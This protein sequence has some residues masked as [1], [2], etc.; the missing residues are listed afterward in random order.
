MSR[1]VEV[2]RVHPSNPSI[3][4]KR[5][6]IRVDTGD[7]IKQIKEKY[8]ANSP[9]RDWI[10]IDLKY[11]DKVLNDNDDVPSNGATLTFESVIM[12]PEAKRHVIPGLPPHLNLS[13]AKEAPATFI[14]DSERVFKRETARALVVKNGEPSS[15]LPTNTNTTTRLPGRDVLCSYSI[16]TNGCVFRILHRMEGDWSGD[17]F[18]IRIDKKSNHEDLVSSTALR[19]DAKERVWF[20][21]RQMIQPNGMMIENFT[22]KLTP[23]SSGIL[24][25][26]RFAENDTTGNKMR[27]RMEER[28]DSANMILFTGHNEDDELVFVETVTLT[29]ENSRVRVS[30]FFRDGKCVDIVTCNE[31][32]RIG[33]RDGAVVKV[34]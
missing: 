4:S 10:R 32:R 24:L 9:K 7:K 12:T 22:V 28:V 30:Q 18:K 31:K 1:T 26:Q 19:F 34:G 16:R 20:E 2:H 14:A 8:L 15:S 3:V 25:G 27:L 21:K 5:T 17:V 6:T 33:A 29:D 13:E 11:G 23:V